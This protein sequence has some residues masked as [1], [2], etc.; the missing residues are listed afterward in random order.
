MFNYKKYK[1][2]Y[3]DKF[4]NT[5]KMNNQFRNIKENTNDAKKLAVNGQPFSN[6]ML[7]VLSYARSQFNKSRRRR[8]K[9]RKTVR[10]SENLEEKY[11]IHDDNNADNN[12]VNNS[13]NGKTEKNYD[14]DISIDFEELV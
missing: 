1:Q 2:G 3:Y 11:I 8:I 13:D 4:N 12:K 5:K 9:K 6:N 10:F 7:M 14:W